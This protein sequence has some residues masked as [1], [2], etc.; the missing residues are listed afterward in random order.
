MGQ[1][2]IRKGFFFYFGLFVLL[3]ISVFLVCLVI[4]MFNPG[5]TV[6]WMKYFTDNNVYKYETTTDG[7]ETP[8]DFSSLSGINIKC[9]SYA[10][11]TLKRNKDA[12]MPLDIVYIVS[13]AKGFGTHKSDVNFVY[14]IRKEG[15][16]LHIE[17][18]EPDGFLFFSRNI[19]IV[20][21]AHTNRSYNFSNIALNVETG[22]GNIEIGRE[23]AGSQEVALKSLKAKTA[24]GDIIFGQTFNSSALTSCEL[25]TSGG[26]IKGYREITYLDGTTKKGQGIALNCDANIDIGN[27][28]L[29]MDAI[30]MGSRTLN[31]KSKKG[32]V[33]VDCIVAGETSVQCHEG[34]YY[35]D[36][37]RGNLSFD[38]AE[39]TLAS[40]NIVAGFISG[41][42]DVSSV[43][44]TPDVTVKEIGGKFSL[45][46]D[47]GKVLVKNA[48]GEVEIDGEG[49]L[50]ADITFGENYSRQA[51]IK[52]NAGELNV[53]FL[54]GILGSGNIIVQ[55]NKSVVNVKVTIAAGFVA[56]AKK[57][58]GSMLADDKINI[59]VGLNKGQSKN[60]LD[61]VGTVGGKGTI[62]ITTNAKVNYELV[63]KSTLV[64]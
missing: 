60:P 40:P 35:V 47:K 2:Q 54:G 7:S 52:N 17:V 8:I 33:D 46:A 64:A 19:E 21:N 62:N 12:N 58:D 10:K 15:S 50:S 42:F 28:W 3:L 56:T 41:N 24:S 6:L 34:N 49:T 51:R 45:V 53:K 30:S 61:V 20:L 31:I 29:G 63:E 43:G 38:P 18:D 59:N 36:S 32:T 57:S 5:K 16:V 23:Y 11:V 13:K 48:K 27:G 14:N 26:D 22:S 9:N 25:T 55:T 37:V 39:D 4:M 1:G 44:G